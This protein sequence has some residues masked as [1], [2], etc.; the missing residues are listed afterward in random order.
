MSQ[1]NL[2]AVP[3]SEEV[4]HSLAL[5]FEE[6]RLPH[7]LILEGPQKERN[8]LAAALAKACVCTD[9]VA[10]PCGKCPGCIKAAA[11]SHPDLFTLD[12]DADPRAFPIDAIRSIRSDAYIRPN[13]ANCKVYLL[14]G[15]QNMSEVSQNALLKVFEEPPE[16]VRFLLTASSAAALLPTIRSRAQIFS[17][18]AVREQ[19][20]VE[21]EYINKLAAA[22]TAA[23]ATD[24]LFLT[25]DLIKNKDRLRAVL[26]ELLLLIRDEAVL[27]AGGSACL[28]G[29]PEAA[30]SLGAGLTRGKLLTLLDE[31]RKAQRALD[32]N[33]NA[34]LLVTALCANL[35]AAA[36]R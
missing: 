2:H 24:L 31:V 6:G 34:A 27:R 17:L 8:A 9:P 25:A 18:E 1:L 4:K 32:R 7:A 21:P 26:S 35:R 10:S 3:V 23:N 20:G 30:A 33:A 19:S 12:G 15:A 36:G 22:V 28:S 5:P 11:G 29:Q 14:Y 13:E 16:S